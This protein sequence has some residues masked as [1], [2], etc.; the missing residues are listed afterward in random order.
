MLML[1]CVIKNAYVFINL[2]LGFSFKMSDTFGR[3]PG[4]HSVVYVNTTPKLGG[5]TGGV[6]SKA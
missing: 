5:E 6:A 2:S 3:L 4:R 1:A